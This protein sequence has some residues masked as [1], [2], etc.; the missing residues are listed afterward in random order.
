MMS[1][2]IISDNKTVFFLLFDRTQCE[3]SSKYYDSSLNVKGLPQYIDEWSFFY[4]ITSINIS[5][6]SIF[7]TQ[8]K[9]DDML[10][11]YFFFKQC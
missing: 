4:Y 5:M 11:I 2:I 1:L 9:I 8:I 6:K 7:K 3:K 10:F